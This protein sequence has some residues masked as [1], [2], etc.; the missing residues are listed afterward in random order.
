VD[1][2][3][4]VRTGGVG[5][6]IGAYSRTQHGGAPSSVLNIGGNNSVSGCYPL[7]TCQTGTA[8]FFYNDLCC[9]NICEKDMVS[10]VEYRRKTGEEG[11][12]QSNP[13]Q[14]ESQAFCNYSA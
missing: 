11:T 6:H 5:G 3:S 10:V 8:G 13:G 2:S 14:A 1:S 4:K 12:F 9:F 7:F